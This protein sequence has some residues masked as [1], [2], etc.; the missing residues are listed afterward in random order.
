MNYKALLDPFERYAEKTLLTAGFA[1]MLAGSLL[2]YLFNGRY[3]GVLDLHFFRQ[4]EWI[5]PFADNIINTAC[6]LLPLFI[7]G[8]IINGRTRVVD[9][10]AAILIARIP[11]YILPVFNA[12]NYLSNMTDR[13]LQQLGEKSAVPG[14]AAADLDISF[15]GV[16]VILIFALVSIVAMIWMIVILFRGFRTATNL[17][18]NGHKV[19]FAL[20]II[21]AEML[22]KIIILKMG[23][24]TEI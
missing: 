7:A 13:L 19:L 17:K 18:T 22:S 11:Y 16:A 23:A 12:N 4:V 8:R 15:L 10:L 1:A 14:L 9:V 3:D 2:A 6:L 24:G 20:A 21:V 5:E